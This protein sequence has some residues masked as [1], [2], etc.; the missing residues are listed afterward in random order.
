MALNSVLRNENRNAL[1]PWLLYLKLILTAL[2][3]VPSK[4]MILWRGVKV[5][6]SHSYEVNKK[7]VWWAFSSCTEQLAVLESELFL[8]TSGERTLF[9]INCD[10]G[11]EIASYSYLPIENEVILPPATQ[12]L[13]KGKLNPSP[14]LHIIQ[15]QEISSTFPL[16]ESPLVSSDSQPV[17]TNSNLKLKQRINRCLPNC[18][19]LGEFSLTDRDVPLIVEEAI[20]AKHCSCL[21]LNHN[22]I[23][24][25]GARLIADVLSRNTSLK[26]L[27][28]WHNHLLDSGANY[29]AEALCSNK[30]LTFLCLTSNGLTE[31]CASN[32]ARMVKENQTLSAF[33]VNDNGIG[34]EGTIM[35]MK[36]L[37]YN[38]TLKQLYLHNNT[39][40]DKSN[41]S[42]EQMFNSNH[43]LQLLSLGGNQF[44]TQV[45]TKLRHLAR[46]K[47]N[48]QFFI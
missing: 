46:E 11:K 16:L 10:N 48:F 39:I 31:A 9:N 27:R 18:M 19:Y 7:Y 20:N 6:L 35:L 2:T 23:T 45:K 22:I 41:N 14:G 40:T 43:T 47:E 21:D 26:V 38:E 1:E 3:R 8:G 32:I 24:A 30:T 36:S 5:D 34:D 17:S 4:K 29:I 44:S 28:F 25:E 42:I 15:L 33:Y 12:F 37:H 13:V